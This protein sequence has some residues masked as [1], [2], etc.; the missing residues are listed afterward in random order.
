MIANADVAS[1][2]IHN[3]VENLFGKSISSETHS[4]PQSTGRAIKAYV[5]YHTNLLAWI[6]IQEQRHPT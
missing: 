4:R 3:I 6:V 1:D 2:T 5:L